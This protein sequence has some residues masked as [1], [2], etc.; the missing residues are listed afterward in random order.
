MQL[1]SSQLEPYSETQILNE[2]YE[3]L[4]VQRLVGRSFDNWKIYDKFTN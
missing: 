1:K 4:G 3:L 2:E